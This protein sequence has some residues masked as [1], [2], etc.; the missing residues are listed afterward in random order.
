MNTSPFIEETY[1]VILKA[2]QANTEAEKVQFCHRISERY[3]IPMDLLRR[4][5]DRCPIVIRK[6]LSLKKA[7][8]LALAFQSYGASVTIEKKRATPPIFLEFTPRDPIL[9]S[10]QSTYL[11]KT[12]G[13]IWQVL[14]RVKNRS[15][16]FMGD[17]WVMIQ[18]FDVADELLLYEES[19]L[20]INPLPPNESSPFKVFV[21]GNPSIKKLTIAFKNASG[22]PISTIDERDQREWV[23]VELDR[24]ETRNIPISRQAEAQVI[25]PLSERIFTEV[26][27]KKEEWLEEGEEKEQ[28]EQT[29]LPE[30]GD[31]Q[32][33]R[34]EL[35][36]QLI[37][38]TKPSADEE[39]PV[40]MALGENQPSEAPQPSIGTILQEEEEL[41]LDDW[42]ENEEGAVRSSESLIPS[43]EDRGQGIEEQAKD[44]V[45]DQEEKPI[46][47]PWMDLFRK[48]IELE[49]ERV[50]DPFIFWF[51]KV[52]QEG[53][54]ESRYH[55]LITL[56][57]YARFHQTP[58][59]E[60]ALNNT[61]KVYRLSHQKDFSSQE[62]PALDGAL[63][64]PGE[65]WRDLF[66]RAI[67]KLQEVSEQILNKKN[68]ELTDLDRLLR[69]IPH[70][71][72]QNSRWT[73]R[74]L[75][76]RFPE[77]GIDLS[78]MGIEVNDG[79]YRIL[80]RLGVIHPL[81]DY[82]QGKHSRGDRKIQAFAQSV[83]SDDPV[84]IEEPLTRLG[85]EGER[86]V[87]LPQNPQCPSC[88]F[89][90]FCPKL[91]LGFNPSEKGMLAR[92]WS[93]D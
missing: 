17:L 91:Y 49:Q 82:Y 86:G 66:I 5:V 46:S 24:F 76:A 25:S 56:L 73:I 16:V 34:E 39:K 69:I 44:E 38:Q 41:H 59:C 23:P 14:G 45:K 40:G 47:Y 35:A 70:M 10:L 50:L 75:R 71:T 9:L 77:I 52:Q 31:L 4:M 43:F 79:I 65:V 85:H 1:R 81:F 36:S 19:P 80:S 67:P 88:P 7:E 29:P 89:E 33:D 13:G 74:V 53:G 18:L 72:A 61:Q 42:Q 62:I 60:N 84:K 21:E 92:S 48:A 12:T 22:V 93:V 63:F 28:L 32:S 11:H 78:T 27:E 26:S 20:P 64:F 15:E 68:W 37:E 83:Y 55:A 87:C 57:I 3:G 54:F 90:S 2:L 6:D 51:D 8:M 58:S 30:V